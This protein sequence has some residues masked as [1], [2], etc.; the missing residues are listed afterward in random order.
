MIHRLFTFAAAFSLLLMI[1]TIILWFHGRTH[2]DGIL[3]WNRGGMVNT[4]S[5]AGQAS[6]SA[7]RFPN[8][9]APARRPAGSN[10]RLSGV[11]LWMEKLEGPDEGWIATDTQHK[12][13]GFGYDY[14]DAGSSQN[15]SYGLEVV[16]PLWFLLLVF[17]CRLVLGETPAAHSPAARPV[18]CLRI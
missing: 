14:L 3:A 6:L 13:A 16:A 12:W 5:T 2:A 7:Y 18:P 9:N 11:S 10:L 1:G 17:A 15:A 8:H 4:L